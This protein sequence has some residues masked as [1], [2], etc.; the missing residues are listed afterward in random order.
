MLSTI[1][2]SSDNKRRVEYAALRIDFSIMYLVMC[3]MTA[4]VTVLLPVPEEKL[5]AGTGLNYN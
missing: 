2:I 4:Q 5:G 1:A 3:S